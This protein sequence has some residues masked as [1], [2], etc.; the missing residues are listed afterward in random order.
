[1]AQPKVTAAA[2]QR[3]KDLVA[4]LDAARPVVVV[5]WE[6]PTH[7]NIRGSAGETVW[8]N[9]EG[10]WTVSVGD[11]HVNEGAEVKTITLGGVEFFF[12]V[13]DVETR[14][15]RLTVDYVGGDFVV[16]Q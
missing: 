14:L 9:T 1:M 3:A 4:Q 2:L 11:L 5:S 16:F 13:P 7:N 10:K 15:D 12:S 8:V 6:P